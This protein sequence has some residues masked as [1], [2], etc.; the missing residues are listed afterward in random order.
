MHIK[1]VCEQVKSPTLKSP[2]SKDSNEKMNFESEIITTEVNQVS[3]SNEIGIKESIFPFKCVICSRLFQTSEQCRFHLSTDHN[4]NILT[5]RTYF[6]RKANQKQTDLEH[7]IRHTCHVCH[8]VFGDKNE[9]WKHIFSHANITTEKCYVCNETFTHC[10][11]LKVHVYCRH[12]VL[13][14][15][16]CY[17]M[18]H[19]VS[20]QQEHAQLHVTEANIP[21]DEMGKMMIEVDSNNNKKER[22]EYLFPNEDK[23]QPMFSLSAKVAPEVLEDNRLFHCLICSKN[24]EGELTFIVHMKTH[25]EP[26][27]LVC[28]LCAKTFKDVVDLEIHLKA[29]FDNKTSMQDLND[30]SGDDVDNIFLCNLCCEVFDSNDE[31]TQHYVEY[32]NSPKALDYPIA[33]SVTELVYKYCNSKEKQM[34]C[35]WGMDWQIS[36]RYDLREMFKNCHSKHSISKQYH[37]PIETSQPIAHELC[38]FCFAQIERTDVK[39]HLSLHQNGIVRGEDIT[40]VY[41][42]LQLHRSVLQ[43]HMELIHPNIYANLNDKEKVKCQFCCVVIS[44]EDIPKHMTQHQKGLPVCSTFIHC[45]YCGECMPKEGLLIHM[46]SKFKENSHLDNAQH[47]KQRGRSRTTSI[48]KHRI[49]VKKLCGDVKNSKKEKHTGKVESVHSAT[50]EEKIDVNIPEG[51]HTDLKKGNS[52][53]HDASAS[54]GITVAMDENQSSSLEENVPSEKLKSPDGKVKKKLK[55]SFALDKRKQLSACNDLETVQDEKDHDFDESK[56]KRINE[57]DKDVSKL[58]NND[59]NVLVTT[60]S[61]C[62]QPI[63]TGLGD[64]N[65][66][67]FREQRLKVVHLLMGGI[68]DSNCKICH[69]EFDTFD[70]LKEHIFKHVDHPDVEHDSRDACCVF[71]VKLVRRTSMRMHLLL[72]HSKEVDQYGRLKKNKQKPVGTKGKENRD[73]VNQYGGQKKQQRSVNAENIGKDDETVSPKRNKQQEKLQE[74]ITNKIETKQKDDMRSKKSKQDKRTIKGVDTKVGQAGK[75]SK[76]SK[77]MVVKAK[78]VLKTSKEESKGEDT[79]IATSMKSG[80]KPGY[81][82]GLQTAA[83][84]YPFNCVVC[85]KGYFGSSQYLS[86]FRQSHPWLYEQEKE[87]IN[88]ERER[89]RKSKENSNVEHVKNNKKKKE[90]DSLFNKSTRKDKVDDIEDSNEEDHEKLLIVAKTVKMEGKAGSATKPRK[91]IRP[92]RPPMAFNDAKKHVNTSINDD[93]REDDEESAPKSSP[94]IELEIVEFKPGEINNDIAAVSNNSEVCKT[95][96]DQDCRSCEEENVVGDQKEVKDDQLAA[97]EN[98]LK[99][100]MEMKSDQLTD[101]KEKQID[102]FE[103]REKELSEERKSIDELECE[104]LG[105]EREINETE[106]SYNEINGIKDNEDKAG[107][108]EQCLEQMECKLV[109]EDEDKRIGL[110]YAENKDTS[111]DDVVMN[112]SSSKGPMSEREAAVGVI[113]PKEYLTDENNGF[114]QNVD[115]KSCTDEVECDSASDIEEVTDEEIIESSSSDDEQKSAIADRKTGDSNIETDPVQSQKAPLSISNVD[116]IMDEKSNDEEYFCNHCRVSFYSQTELNDH[117]VVHLNKQKRFFNVPYPYVCLF[118]GNG[119]YKTYALKKHL[120]SKHT[121]SYSEGME[122]SKSCMN[123]APGLE[124]DYEKGKNPVDSTDPM[125][126]QSEVG[127]NDYECGVSESCLQETQIKD[128]EQSVADDE[129]GSVEEPMTI[130]E[131]RRSSGRKRSINADVLKFLQGN[132][133]KKTFDKDLSNSTVKMKKGNSENNEKGAAKV[134]LEILKEKKRG[135]SGVEDL[136]DPSSSEESTESEEKTC[137]DSSEEPKETRSDSDSCSSDEIKV[138]CQLCDVAVESKTKLRKHEKMHD[139]GDKKSNCNFNKLKCTCCKRMVVRHE[140]KWHMHKE[141]ANE[142]IVLSTRKKYCVK[143]N[144]GSKKNLEE[145]ISSQHPELLKIE[146]RL[147]DAR[148][149]TKSLYKKHFQVTHGKSM[150]EESLMCYLCNKKFLSLPSLHKHYSLTHMKKKEDLYCSLC[151]KFFYDLTDFEKHQEEYHKN[152][153][154][155]CG[156]CL[157]EFGKVELCESHVVVHKEKTEFKCKLCS[158]YFESSEVLKKHIA[159]HDGQCFTCDSCGRDFESLSEYQSHKSVHS[160]ATLTCPKCDLTFSDE[161][162]LFEHGKTHS[163]QKTYQCTS[164]EKSFDTFSTIRQH[165]DGVHHGGARAICSENEQTEDESEVSNLSRTLNHCEACGETFIRPEIFEEHGRKCGQKR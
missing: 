138:V 108:E 96:D 76:N 14:C 73:M 137:D 2:S 158:F 139:G 25:A 130:L 65:K 84:P 10:S 113:E 107:L 64:T 133:K 1:Y 57:D 92:G 69:W 33:D 124:Q 106:Q 16:C 112:G 129:F 3:K 101:E 142:G 7:Q 43:S 100:E 159:T 71:C 91:I 4:I 55:G 6:L 83:L 153:K 115:A 136:E 126:D 155:Q 82:Y 160:G 105:K 12:K 86:H 146:C 98:K 49:K 23:Y 147:C 156:L 109:E 42:G 89:K 97:N 68:E 131:N 58:A 143:C 22:T 17:K 132:K 117:L 39:Q 70:D 149:S 53:K 62:P 154:F 148:Y 114:D 163:I 15:R 29:H 103:K 8:L 11:E 94:E 66:D 50:M 40:C 35:D 34:N 46:Q 125:A 164:C 38:Q 162:E 95:V 121:D 54:D 63:D 150:D 127:H 78:K 75:F 74:N 13:F 48:T 67:S 116:R 44:R 79:V 56:M 145:H 77:E 45:A 135:K 61:V 152:D 27:P 87:K 41:C 18:F 30:D 72:K 81:V 36:E 118:C 123:C 119:F 31:L 37:P 93:S 110:E 60:T 47:K 134:R 21:R 24:I 128:V 144:Y 120:Q 85:A 122:N 32:K 111:I 157:I 80:L 26:R 19:N 104:P 20:Q 9:L 28:L 141:H 59:N 165:M 51:N 90:E 88:L 140:L 99:T 52:K 161:K 151:S 5:L 102:R